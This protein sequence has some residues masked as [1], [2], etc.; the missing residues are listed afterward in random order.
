MI[1]YPLDTVHSVLQYWDLLLD[2]AVIVVNNNM[3][4]T[5]FEM[6]G[7]ILTIL[8]KETKRLWVRLEQLHYPSVHFI[9]AVGG[10][11]HDG[12]V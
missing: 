7:I 6:E 10:S 5:I 3:P 12:E 2:L 9:L 4:T 11:L 8:Y 1:R